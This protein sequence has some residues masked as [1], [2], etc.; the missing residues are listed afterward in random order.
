MKRP[1]VVLVI[2]GTDPLAG[3]GVVA[4]AIHVAAHGAWPLSVATAEVRQDSHGVRGFASQPLDDVMARVEHALRDGRPDAIKVGMLASASLADALGE[5]LAAVGAPVVMDPVLA[6]GTQAAPSLHEEGVP[7]ALRR[8][9]ARCDALLTPNIAELLALFR[10]DGASTAQ[11]LGE[12]ARALAVTHPAP[13]LLK[14]GHASPPGTDWLVAN[15]EVHELEPHD[16]AH[17]DV[18][19]TGCALSTAIA[20]RRARGDELVDAVRASRSWL[21]ERVRTHTAQVGTGRRQFVSTPG[22]V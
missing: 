8:A 11:E 2:G 17:A 3:A 1:P 7:A 19:G 21:A 9:A 13:L 18:H 5:R 15:G 20:C 16:W 6:G 22:V 4:D 14:G 10:V 12:R